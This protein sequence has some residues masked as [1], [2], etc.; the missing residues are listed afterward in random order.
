MK[1]KLKF[2]SLKLFIIISRNFI[3]DL[4]FLTSINSLQNLNQLT[5]KFLENGITDISP[6]ANIGS[7][8]NLNLLAL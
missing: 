5:L 8:T 1:F 2:Y 3:S 7:L 6:L 4:S